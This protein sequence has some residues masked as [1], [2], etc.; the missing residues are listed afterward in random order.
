MP[1][2]E[3]REFLKENCDEVYDMPD[4]E[5]DL[6]MDNHRCI[7]WYGKEYFISRSLSFYDELSEKIYDHLYNNYQL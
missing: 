5:L 2:P 4:H 6:M 1:K 3:I 7:N